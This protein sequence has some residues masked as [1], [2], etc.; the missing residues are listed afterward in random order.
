MFDHQ[1]RWDAWDKCSGLVHWED[2]QESGGEVGSGWGIHVNPWLIHVS[3]W[4]N[5]LQCCEVISL[6]LTEINGKKKRLNVCQ[7]DRWER[8]LGRQAISLYFLH[9]ILNVWSSGFCLHSLNY[10]LLSALSQ[11]VYSP[12]F[13]YLM[14]HCSITVFSSFIIFFPSF[15]FF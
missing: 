13:F 11:A 4:Q 10:S 6:Q 1:P 3:V 8:I 5:P 12:W 14:S 2:P 9:F 7:A 15:F